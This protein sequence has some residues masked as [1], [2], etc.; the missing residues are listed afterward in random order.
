MNA[1]INIH[2][3]FKLTKPNKLKTFPNGKP[4]NKY[5]SVNKLN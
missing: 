2:N 3:F 1:K 5:R 4:K